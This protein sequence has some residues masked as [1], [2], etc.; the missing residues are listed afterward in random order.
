[1]KRIKPFPEKSNVLLVGGGAR[2]FAAAKKMKE[3]IQH[4]IELYSWANTSNPG[5]EALSKEMKIGRNYPDIADFARKRNIGLAFIGPEEPAKYGVVDD[6][7]DK[8]GIPT[9]GLTKNLARLETSKSFTRK[10]LEKYDIPGNPKFKIFETMEG[11]EEYLDENAPVVLKPNGLTGGK[12][13]QVQGEHFKTV[14]E[15]LE[16]C[17]EILNEHD[18][19]VIEEK[20]EGEEF[21]LQFLCDGITIVPNP[22]VRDYKRRLNGDKGVNTG[23]MGSY[24][25]ANHLLPFITKDDLNQAYYIAKKTVEALYEEAK[26][27]YT[28][29]LYGGFMVT[30][31]GVKLIEFNVR[32]G[33]PEAINVL[34]TLETD[35]MEICWAMASPEIYGGLDQLN[36]K[37]KPIATVVKYV[38]PTNYAVKDAKLF[39]NKPSLIRINDL[40]RAKLYYS[41]VERNKVGF[42]MTYSRAVAILG[43]GHTLAEAEKI[44]ERGVQGI[45]GAIAYRSDIGTA[46]SIEKQTRHME[47]LRKQIIL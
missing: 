27:L 41:L 12:G 44:A 22:P 26:D 5:I 14:V 25:C 46:A 28:G 39:T 1:M 33:D 8:C 38:V 16:I 19:I 37:F 6:L 45:S 36:I 20:L 18:S 11:I 4:E 9:V 32:F 29:V 42:H 47:E 3:S 23:G 2:E 10:L 31:N 15:A 21:S 24:S 43:T 17:Q 13:V 40:E 34:S 35:F 7:R 30:A